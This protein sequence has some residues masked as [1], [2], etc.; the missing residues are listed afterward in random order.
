MNAQVNGGVAPVN[1]VK[2]AP[3]RA[4][5]RA[6]ARR[7]GRGWTGRRQIAAAVGGVGGFVLLLSVWDCTGALALLTG[8]PVALCGLLA[9]GI[10]AGM[11][12]CEMA[13]VAAAPEK[14]PAHWRD[15]PE[16]KRWADLYVLGAVALSVALNAT[17]AASH[18]SGALVGLAAA[19]GACVPLL[20]YAAG[21]VAGALWA[22]R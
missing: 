6:R 14:K 9:V 20:V 21:R 13:A 15:N 4:G 12:A 22:G 5:G 16:A 2:G 8:M 18:A 7:A 1:R 17:A 10:D 3:A 11:V 19:V